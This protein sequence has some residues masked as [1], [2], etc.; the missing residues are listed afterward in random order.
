MGVFRRGYDQL[1]TLAA[2]AEAQSLVSKFKIELPKL[3]VTISEL[4]SKL[5]PKL[6]IG[7]KEAH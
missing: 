6:E 2:G 3:S 5:F 7:V 4:L 1:K